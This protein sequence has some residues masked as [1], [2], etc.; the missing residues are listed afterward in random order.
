MMENQMLNAS[1]V[2]ELLNIHVT[3]LVRNLNKIDLP[4]LR[5]GRCYKFKKEDVEKFIQRNMKN[6]AA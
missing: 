5:F 1:D 3:T 4:Y 6:H 2:S